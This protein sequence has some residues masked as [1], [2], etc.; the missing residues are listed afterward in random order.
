M[1]RPRRQA[2]SHARRAPAR[3]LIFLIEMYR[4]CV[5]PLRLPACRFSPTCSQYAVDALTEYGLIRG[6]WLAA[7][8]LAKCGPWHRGGWDPIPERKPGA[9]SSAATDV[10]E[11]P[12]QRGESTSC[13]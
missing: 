6:G 3:V 9:R 12:A 5:S 2:V 8:R 13:V 11:R 7:L 10:W 1:N 4:T